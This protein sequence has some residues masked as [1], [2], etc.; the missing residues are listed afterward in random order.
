MAFKK[1]DVETHS[2]DT[3]LNAQMIK[4]KLNKLDRTKSA[5]IEIQKK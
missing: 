5:I 2:M 4:E 3:E 1:S